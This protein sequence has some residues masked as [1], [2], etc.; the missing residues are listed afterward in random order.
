[1]NRT[2]CELLLQAGFL[3]LEE[4]IREKETQINGVV[5]ILDSKGMSW[6]HTKQVGYRHL[7]KAAMGLQVRIAAVGHFY[8]Y[9]QP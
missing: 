1:L 2:S 6:A 5:C 7:Q 9:I 3:L 8:T 4:V